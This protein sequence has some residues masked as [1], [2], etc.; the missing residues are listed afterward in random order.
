MKNNFASLRKRM[1][2]EQLINR[3][4]Q[5]KRVLDA[6][7]KIPRH[8]FIPDDVKKFAYDDSPLPIGLGQTISQPYMVAAMTELLDLNESHILLE[9]GTG[10]GYQAAIASQLCKYVYTVE[11]IEELAYFAISNLNN[12]GIANVEV[13]IGDGSKGYPDKAPYDR[14]LYTAAAPFVPDIIFEQLTDNGIIVVPE[15]ERH[16]QMLKRYIKQGNNI[17]SCLYFGCIFVPLKGDFGFEH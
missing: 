2:E 16:S 7:L 11:R 17:E 12:I 1:I 6:F 9:I 15:G 4:I 5:D 10:S 8:K 14:I 13:I 3:G